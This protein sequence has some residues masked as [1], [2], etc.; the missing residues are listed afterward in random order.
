MEVFKLGAKLRGIGAQMIDAETAALIAVSR[1]TMPLAAD[2][3]ADAA[4]HR[5]RQPFAVADVLR[6]R[7]WPPT[8]LADVSRL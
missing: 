3:N 5:G 2:A 6:P 8:K 7:W 4:R 1:V